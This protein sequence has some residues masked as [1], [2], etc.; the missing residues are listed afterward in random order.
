V[1]P[2]ARYANVLPYLSARIES[3]IA[4]VQRR[5]PLV[6]ADELAR[7]GALTFTGDD[8][9][10]LQAGV[11]DIAVRAVVMFGMTSEERSAD[12]VSIR[13]DLTLDAQL[14]D[15][16]LPADL[17]KSLR[18]YAEASVSAIAKREANVAE[19]R[20]AAPTDGPPW[21]TYEGTWEDGRTY[22]RGAVTTDRG[23]LWCAQVES[24]SARPGS[25]SAWKLMAKTTQA[26]R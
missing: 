6:A 14:L 12:V 18:H 1:S 20:S 21:L 10:T 11:D 4:S 22:R 8:G 7:L 2:I 15:A 17:L 23:A 9:D 3:E 25:S 13:D 5:A 26:S 24:V 19:T 16:G